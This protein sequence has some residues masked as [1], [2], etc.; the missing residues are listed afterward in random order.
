MQAHCRYQCKLLRS[1]RSHFQLDCMR[2]NR[3]IQLCTSRCGLSLIAYYTEVETAWSSLLPEVLGPEEAAR[4][5]E[6]V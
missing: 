5:N 3:W 1:V 6:L 2:L 4:I